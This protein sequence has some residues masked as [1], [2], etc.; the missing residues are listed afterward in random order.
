M[1]FCR[2]EVGWTASRFRGWFRLQQVA[3][4]VNRKIILR[5][6]LA[7]TCQLRL[8]FMQNLHEVMC[9][10]RLVDDGST[11]GLLSRPSCSAERI[12]AGEQT[13]NA[14]TRSVSFAAPRFV[15]LAQLPL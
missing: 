2:R 5:S 9:E 14:L 1:M 10:Y 8:N 3:A 15:F 11:A 7:V 12:S 4:N 13:R 6:S